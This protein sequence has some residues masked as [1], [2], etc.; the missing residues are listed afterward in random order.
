MNH[1]TNAQNSTK[2][3]KYKKNPLGYVLYG[4]EKKT[5]KKQTTIQVDPLVTQYYYWFAISGPLH[6]QHCNKS[7]M[8]AYSGT[9]KL[10]M[11]TN[12][13]KMSQGR[14]STP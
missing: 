5:K 4:I 13:S 10:N 9:H 14:T 2:N 1:Q 7:S 8:C 3:K 12:A 11:E 6:N